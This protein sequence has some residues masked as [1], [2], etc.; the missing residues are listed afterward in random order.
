MNDDDGDD[1]GGAEPLE[2]AADCYRHGM[3]D[4]L[5]RFEMFLKTVV[6]GADT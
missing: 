6:D 5:M 3:W 2:G 1:E 4:A